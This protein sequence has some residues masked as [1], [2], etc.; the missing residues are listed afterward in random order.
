MT[1]IIKTLKGKDTTCKPIWFMRQAGRYL[2]EFRE[3]RETNSDF[4]KLCLNSD[5]TK[6]ITLQPIQRFKLDAAIIFSDILM[7]PHALGQKVVFEKNLGP[8]ISEF[9]EKNFFKISEEEFTSKLSSVYKA[10][11]KTRKDLN[12]SKSLIGFSAAPWTLIYYMFNLKNKSYDLIKKQNNLISK[13]LERLNVFINLH[14]KN[15]KKAGADVAQ[16]FDSWAGLLKEEDL[17]KYCILPNKKIVGLSKLARTVE[18]FSKR[19]QTQERL[20]MQIANAL[21]KGLDANGVAVTVDATHQCMTMRGIKKE[22]A[23]TITN[24]FAGKFKEDLSYQN[25]YLKYIG[26]KN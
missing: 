21:M 18:V 23:T 24:Y 12:A 25:R 4:I 17:E 3:I 13:V 14:L 6:K 1:P 16:I 7:I 5:L 9:N 10:I 22:R 15:Q 2:P 19:L 20:T 26:D 11:K 8:V